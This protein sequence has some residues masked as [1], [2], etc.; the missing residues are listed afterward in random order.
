MTFPEKFLFVRLEICLIHNTFYEQENP[1]PIQLT[2]R[3][4]LLSAFVNFGGFRDTIRHTFFAACEVYPT[5][6]LGWLPGWERH[7][8]PP[9]KPELR[10]PAALWARVLLL[11]HGT[12]AITSI[13][14][15]FWLVPVIFCLGPFYGGFLFY[16]CN[17][18]QHVG[19]KANTADFRLCC[20]SF[21]LHPL[22]SFLYWQMNFHTEHHMYANVPCYNLPRLHDAIKHDLPPTPEGLVG[23]WRVI[24]DVLERQRRDPAYTQPILLPARASERPESDSCA[25]R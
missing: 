12:I 17:S 1:L 13:A 24:I 9:E 18:T 11:G 10:R 3:D 6:H 8:Y 2:L 19:L 4:F 5:G 14:M 20:R 16:L 25:G 15:G 7:I 21:T 22:I 23:V